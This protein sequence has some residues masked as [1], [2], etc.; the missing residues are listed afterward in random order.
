MKLFNLL[1]RTI[2]IMIGRLCI[3]V[4]KLMTQDLPKDEEEHLLDDGTLVL[5]TE[6][7]LTDVSRI[8]VCQ[9][10]THYGDLYYRDEDD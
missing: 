4:I 5:Y 7:D 2:K 8:N 1:W 10:G 6:F 9:I 3:K